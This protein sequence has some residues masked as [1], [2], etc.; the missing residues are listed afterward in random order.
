M[1]AGAA[2]WVGRWERLSRQ[3]EFQQQISNL[4][5]ALQRSLNRYTE[6]L[7]G[8]GDLYRAAN[9]QV[10]QAEFSQFVERA[11][12][13]YPGIQALEWAPRVAAEARSP[14]EATLPPGSLGITERDPRNMLIAALGDRPD[15]FPVTYIEP[16]RGNEVA[17]GYD[18]ASE[19]TRRLALERA[20]DTGK[21]A[22]TARLRLVQE[23]AEAQYSFLVFLPI[24]QRP[25]LT[26]TERRR[27]H[28]GYVLGVFRV[29]DVVE[30]SLQD[31]DYDIDFYIHD[32]TATPN[33]QFLGFY[34]SE[35]GRLVSLDSAARPDRVYPKA[36]CP[37]ELACT[38]VVNFGQRE[39]SILFVPAADYGL[40]WRPWGAIATFCLGLL[41]T[42]GIA[43]YAWRSQ[44]ALDRTRELNDLKMRFFSMASHEL[45]TPLSTIL[46]TA[47]SLEANQT[48][49]TPDQKHTSVDRIHSAARRM[50]QLLDD[51]LTLT[52]AEAGKLEFTPEI[53]DLDAFCQGI[54][55][56]LR[57]QAKPGQTLHYELAIADPKAYLD[58]KLG[59]S[60]LHN[61]LA[62]ALKYS[63][64]PSTVR[65]R[66]WTDPTTLWLEVTDAG[67]GIPAHSQAYIVEAFYRGSNVGDIPGTGLGLAVVK[68]CVDCHQG[69]IALHSSPAQ[70]TRITVGL[71]RV[72]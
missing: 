65:L 64:V 32:H 6:L 52:R 47:Q 67:M 3:Q 11:V 38:Q 41:L 59:R 1:S 29:A 14:Y 17:L 45:R 63:P 20:R 21:L 46:L 34:S 44:S 27:S 16:W 9:N 62:N 10:S 51:I 15:Y 60:L 43:G 24:Y 68:T 50:T 5:T 56:E 7:L 48:I 35:S 22:A 42:G 54:L 66:V 55:D 28:I 70:G 72:D 61:L 33:E 69:T 30:E 12:S 49:L 31:L 18:L 53:V 37:T 23:T 39:W 26:L 8:L 40:G 58:P 25:A 71:P 57:L 13:S 4:N 36:L 2:Q 19:R